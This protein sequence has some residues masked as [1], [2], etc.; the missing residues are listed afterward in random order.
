MAYVLQENEQSFKQLRS[1]GNPLS[2]AKQQALANI[3]LEWAKSED[4]RWGAHS[5]LRNIYRNVSQFSKDFLSP[6]F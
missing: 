2:V 3:H 6:L 4:S 5:G 1:K